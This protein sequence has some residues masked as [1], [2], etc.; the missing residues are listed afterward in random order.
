MR[1]MAWLGGALALSAATVHAG[2]MD[3]TLDQVLR[4][5]APGDTVSALVYLTEQLDTGDL[6]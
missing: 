3:P 2:I 4:E 5:T 6:R 1:R